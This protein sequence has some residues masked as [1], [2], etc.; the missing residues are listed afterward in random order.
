MRRGFLDKLI[1]RVALV[2]PG[3]VQN[4][5]VEIAR[6]KGFLETIFNAILEGVIVTDPK[7]RI[8]YLNQAACG[9]FGIKSEASLGQPLAEVVRGLDWD[10]LGGLGGEV[11]SRDLE[12]F[13]PDN[14]LLNFYVVPLLSDEIDGGERETVGRAI[15]L[16]D[17]TQTRRA[18]EETI[19]SERF[20]ALTM[21]AAGVAHEVGNPLNSLDIHLQLMQ[22]SLQ[23][24][25]AKSRSELEK[26]VNVARGEVSRLDHIITQFLRAIRPQ[27]LDLQP[28]RVNS[29]VEESIAFLEPE[30]QDRDVLVEC[31]L[32]PGLP[33]LELD[34][35]QIKQAFYNVVRNS[36]QAM[37]TGGILRIRTGADETHVNVSFSDTGGGIPPEN[38]SRIFEPY[39]TTKSGGSGLGLLIVRRIIRAHGGEVVLESAS[40]KG[41]TL[42]LR[43]PRADRRVRF[44]EQGSDA[45][46]PP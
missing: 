30:I 25:P 34:R 10:G 43:L 9:F 8:I 26:A 42:T 33:A 12:V 39:F 15:I 16:R 14:R 7:G 32:D 35:D 11:I 6:E 21:L 20:S 40:G 2:H 22:R 28:G 31:D 37:K 45:I 13:Y 3:E 24:L 1:E 41:L 27:P 29:I 46:L 4:Y 38:I 18:T 23:K 19:E 5:L 44:L 36:F 17:I